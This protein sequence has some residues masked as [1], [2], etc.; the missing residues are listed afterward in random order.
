MRKS[1]F[2]AIKMTF[3]KI[4]ITIV[5]IF[6]IFISILFIRQKKDIQQLKSEITRQENLIRNVGGRTMIWKIKTLTWK[7][8]LIIWK[9]ELTM[10]KVIVTTSNS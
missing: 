4:A 6:C 3:E 10:W 9:V 7:D 5:L 8:K 2:I 1:N